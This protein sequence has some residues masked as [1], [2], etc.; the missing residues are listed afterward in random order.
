MYLVLENITLLLLMV[1]LIAVGVFAYLNQEQ[2]LK[3]SGEFLSA[4]KD[5]R[6]KNRQLTAL[7]RQHL[8]L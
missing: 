4:A 6:R 1:A 2:Y 7:A 8:E 5:N 3:K